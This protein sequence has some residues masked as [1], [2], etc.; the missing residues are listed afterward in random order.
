MREGGKGGGRGGGKG[1]ERRGKE[2]VRHFVS[3][4]EDLCGQLI[5]STLKIIPFLLSSRGNVQSCL[6]FEWVVK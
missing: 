6:E 2:R 5:N 3:E 1:C 4:K